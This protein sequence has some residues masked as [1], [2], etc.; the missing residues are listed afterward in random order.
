[1]WTLKNG[2]QTLF[3]MPRVAVVRGFALNNLL[4]HRGQLTVYLRLNDIPV[5]GLYGASADEK[6]VPV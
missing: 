5:P 1:T 6:N 4:H 2:S 3:T